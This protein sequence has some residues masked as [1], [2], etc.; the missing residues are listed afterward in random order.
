MKRKSWKRTAAFVTSLAMTTT[1]LPSDLSGIVTSIVHADEINLSAGSELPETITAGPGETWTV[2]VLPGTVKDETNGTNAES[3]TYTGVVKINESGIFDSDDNGALPV[4]TFRDDD[5]KDNTNITSGLGIYVD[6]ID[7]EKKELTLTWEDPVVNEGLHINFEPVWDDIISIKQNGS[8]VHITGIDQ[9]FTKVK[10]GYEYVIRSKK[11]LNI[12]PVVLQNENDVRFS[13]YVKKA[14]ENAADGAKYVYTFVVGRKD[15]IIAE[16][17]TEWSVAQSIDPNAQPIK[18][19][20][21]DK[22][23]SIYDVTNSE[24]PAILP[25]STVYPDNRYKIG[26][27]IKDIAVFEDT[28]GNGVL[29]LTGE[30]KDLRVSSP[31]SLNSNTNEYE[32]TF[33]APY[34]DIF[35]THADQNWNFAVAENGEE[36]TATST[37]ITD[38]DV[39]YHFGFDTSNPI[40]AGSPYD[41]VVKPIGNADNSENGEAAAVWSTLSCQIVISYKDKNGNVLDAQPENAGSYKAVADIY[42]YDEE[43]ACSTEGIGDY[44]I[45]KEFKISPIDDNLNV[46]VV[47]GWTIN[48][49]EGVYVAYPNLEILQKPK[50]QDGAWVRPG[51]TVKNGEKTLDENEDYIIE[52][53]VTSTERGIHTLVIVGINDY[54]GIVQE[55]KWYSDAAFKSAIIRADSVE[56]EDP[57]KVNGL[58][59]E[60]GDSFDFAL[61]EFEGDQSGVTYKLTPVFEKELAEKYLVADQEQKLVFRAAYETVFGNF[62][63]PTALPESV[64]VTEDLLIDVKTFDAAG[65]MAKLE[66]D[67]TSTLA[68]INTLTGINYNENADNLEV[69]TELRDYINE[70]TVSAVNAEETVATADITV[71][72]KKVKVSFNKESV[73]YDG[74]D[75]RSEFK[76]FTDEVLEKDADAVNAELGK[77][78]ITLGGDTDTE[79]MPMVNAL[80]YEFKAVPAEV[81]KALGTNYALL[82]NIDNGAITITAKVDPINLNGFATASAPETVL[83]TTGGTNYRKP[84]ITVTTAEGTELFKGYDFYLAGTI[85][86]NKEGNYTTKIQGKNNYTGTLKLDWSVID[87]VSFKK[88]IALSW[89]PTTGV[90]NGSGNPAVKFTFNRKEVPEFSEGFEVTALGYVYANQENNNQLTAADLTVENKGKEKNGNTIKVYNAKTPSFSGNYSLSIADKGFGVT[91]RAFVTLKNVATNTEWTVYTDDYA[92]D[93]MRTDYASAVNAQMTNAFEIAEVQTPPVAYTESSKNKLQA[94]FTITKNANASENLKVVEA[95]Y[96]YSNVAEPAGA[97]DISKWQDMTLEAA[98]DTANTFIKKTSKT[99]ANM[100]SYTVKF[101]DNGAGVRYRAF[102]VVENEDG[103]RFIKYINY[104]GD[105]TANYGA[106]VTCANYNFADISIKQLKKLVTVTDECV[107]GN[108]TANDGKPAARFESTRK[109]DE[110][111][112]ESDVTV[113]EYGF[114]YANG[115]DSAPDT[116]DFTVEK[117]NVSATDA[118]KINKKA[119]S[120]ISTN[121]VTYSLNIKKVDN[122]KVYVRGFVKVKDNKTGIEQ[123]IYADN[124]TA[125]V[126]DNPVTP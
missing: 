12:T 119:G 89:M 97:A 25:N 98:N 35:I 57:V 110:S 104:V 68:A 95:G 1:M 69:I 8:E 56:D 126:E 73:T 16:R 61:D 76:L 94:K 112:A 10:T 74:K 87:G 63:P 31:R 79:K 88:A 41:F 46:S 65:I 29:D 19:S 55:F 71:V 77:I 108:T 86:A 106:D 100:S 6:S 115:L 15:V 83:V 36:I 11:A 5:D 96:I 82:N 3:K 9:E 21:D 32:Y 14:E 113:S 39:V 105:N 47:D 44:H 85:S 22:N 75:H 114:I 58:D 90:I 81:V 111:A 102:I 124:I 118:F 116:T 70:Y 18:I 37:E 52:G 123:Y 24:N 23:T 92:A 64:N 59:Y 121:G 49:V 30:N 26:S 38:E 33:T 120:A 62:V 43:G 42:L 93:I 20:G 109:L 67:K 27:T 80:K 91:A 53:E 103:A 60:Y 48:S 50:D 125:N 40:T 99:T 7:A 107:N 84:N 117:A 4:A 51:I 45:E 2:T 101:V 13:A 66:N 54:D 28:N 122:N 78:A 34:N 72:A 17:A